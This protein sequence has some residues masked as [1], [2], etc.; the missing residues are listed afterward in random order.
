[1]VHEPLRELNL[2]TDPLNEKQKSPD[3]G[4]YAIHVATLV[5]GSDEDFKNML[6]SFRLNMGMK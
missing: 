4:R 3:R 5:K 1:M 2:F 6:N